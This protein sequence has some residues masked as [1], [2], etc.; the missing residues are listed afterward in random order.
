MPNFHTHKFNPWACQ[1]HSWR[2]KGAHSWKKPKSWN[3]Q[4]EIKFSAWEKF[5]GDHHPGLTDEELQ[6]K[7]FIKPQRPRVFCGVDIFENKVPTKWR[8]DFFSL[9]GSTPRLD[10]LLLTQHIKNARAMLPEKFDLDRN[11][12]LGVQITNQEEADRDIPQ[13]LTFP[14]A[15]RFLSMEPLL[16]KVNLNTWLFSEHGRRL[17]GARPG[18]YLVRVGGE[19]GPDARPM[20]PDWV[21]SLRDQCE[22]AGVSFWFEG[23][24]DWAEAALIP[25]GDLGGEMRRGK[26]QHLHAPGNPE[27]G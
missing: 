5:K 24:G 8:E 23:W 16:G 6:A 1:T 26:V 10:W 4:A 27:R 15:K 18:I 14:A 11:I 22:K 3:S 13:L 21:R 12:W 25:G 2:E 19:T 7:G 9:I 17:I 20:H